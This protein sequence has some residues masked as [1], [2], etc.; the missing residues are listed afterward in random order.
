MSKVYLFWSLLRGFFVTC[1]PSLILQIFFIGAVEMPVTSLVSFMLKCNSFHRTFLIKF[2]YLVVM[3]YYLQCSFFLSRIQ[4]STLHPS[5]TS[6]FPKN[7]LVTSHGPSTP[8]SL[9][10][11]YDWEKGGVTELE[12]DATE[13]GATRLLRSV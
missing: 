5:Q 8:C 11:L 13:N 2:E 10:D 12:R 1:L 6:S 4:T 3:L 9:R 7:K